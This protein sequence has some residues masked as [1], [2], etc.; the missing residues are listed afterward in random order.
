MRVLT[1]A[2]MAVIAVGGARSP[3]ANRS[4]PSPPS[5]PVTVE[6]LIATLGRLEEV[7]DGA[8]AV[9]PY[10][11]AMCAGPS[12]ETL[13]KAKKQ[14]GPHTME[15]IRVSMNEPAVKA[16]RAKTEYPPGA[17]VVKRKR[18]GAVGGMIKREPGYVDLGGDWEYF[19]SETGEYLYRG[20]LDSCRTCHM[21]TRST[22][23]VFGS[24]RTKR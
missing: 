14:F 5:T 17:A 6:D 11:S 20:R 19:Y 24:W 21:T 9:N 12:P 3:S 22:D 8:V 16:F 10:L 23:H 2:V 4:Q 13:A 1:I 15:Y 7:S 18:M